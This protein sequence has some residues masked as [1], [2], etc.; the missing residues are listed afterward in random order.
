MSARSAAG[1]GAFFGNTNSAGSVLERKPA[2]ANCLGLKRPAG[3]EIYGYLKRYVDYY[4]K[5]P[6]S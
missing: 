6:A 2:R 5:R 1:P 3:K 4:P